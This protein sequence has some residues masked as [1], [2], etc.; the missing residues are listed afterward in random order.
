MADFT[1][2][3]IVITS[4]AARLNE[5]PQINMSRIKISGAGGIG[6]LAM[7]GLIAVALPE[8]RIFIAL[9][10]V[11][12]TLTGIALIRYRH[13]HGGP[14]DSDDREHPLFDG[15]AERAPGPDATARPRILRAPST[16]SGLW[17]ESHW[18]SWRRL[19][20][21]PVSCIN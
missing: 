5:P 21:G 2:H 17:L 13:A 20:R 10:L 12:G 6:M 18:R 11:V 4:R 16:L 19:P 8:V 14:W 1:P 3:P 9:S 7:A 15:Q